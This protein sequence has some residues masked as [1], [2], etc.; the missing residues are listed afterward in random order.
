MPDQNDPNEIKPANQRGSARLGAVQALYQM[1]VGGTALEKILGEFAQLRLGQ[2][3]E[4]DTYRDADVDYFNLIVRGVV[5]NQAKV[6]PVIEH[7]LVDRWPLTRLD[8][9][10]RAILRCGCFELIKRN[11]VPAKV[12]VSEYVDIAKA[13]YEGEE[14]KMVNAVLDNIAKQARA[15][16]LKGG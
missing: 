11:D 8:T 14:P 6:D 7:A 15:T 4:G 16:E 1:E 9:T 10:L 3:I 13:F 2:E 5:E 12:V